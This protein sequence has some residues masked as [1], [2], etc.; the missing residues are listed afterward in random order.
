[1]GC[2]ALRDKEHYLTRG[3]NNHGQVEWCA[4][5]EDEVLD[6]IMIGF[7]K[8]RADLAELRKD[9]EIVDWLAQEHEKTWLGEAFWDGHDPRIEMS[10]PELR[11]RVH[12]AMQSKSDRDPA[13][14]KGV[15]E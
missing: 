4:E 14:K 8:D 10:P 1:M 15:S 5:C 9:R 13:A 12:A 6:D 7:W 11:R 3:E 2:D